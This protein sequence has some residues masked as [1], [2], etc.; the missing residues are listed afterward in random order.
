MSVKTKLFR[1]RNPKC[2]VNGKPLDFASEQPVCPHCKIEAKDER[3]GRFILR[4][5]KVHYDPQSGV[6]GYGANVR[7]C[8]PNV[9]I[10]ATFG[11]TGVPEPWHA[12]TGDLGQVSCPECLASAA[13][14]ADK[15]AM[16]DEAAAHA[17]VQ[18]SVERLLAGA[19]PC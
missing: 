7:A 4:R 2:K 9:S 12:G 8:D 16:E 5:V 11:P 19:G 3:F 17:H 14:A 10:C 18:G 1:C 13:F 6:P 15:K